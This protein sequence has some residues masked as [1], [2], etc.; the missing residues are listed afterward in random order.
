M[1]I[2]GFWLLSKTSAGQQVASTSGG[3][4]E[5]G[6]S[7]IQ[8]TIG[9]PVIGTIGDETILTQGFQQ[10][11]L[12]VTSIYELKTKKEQFTIY[13][14]PVEFE[15]FVKLENQTSDYELTLLDNLGTIVF[16]K[17]EELSK[18]PKSIDFSEV[19][20]G[21]YYLRIANPNQQVLQTFTI[22]KTL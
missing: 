18:R 15:L 5:T 13:P 9:E 12:T 14:N 11:R 10:S 3:Q 8:W 19:V 16:T 6:S 17:K 7:H 2:A 1:C 22:I 20:P 21:I 4:G